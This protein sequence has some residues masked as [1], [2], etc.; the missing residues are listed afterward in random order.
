MGLY[1]SS[2]S[3]RGLAQDAQSNYGMAG[4]TRQGSIT[5][6]IA[7]ARQKVFA[8]CSPQW[9]FVILACFLLLSVNLGS[10]VV[11]PFLPVMAPK[12][13]ISRTGVA[14]VMATYSA[15]QIMASLIAGPAAT[16]FGRIPVL[17]VGSFV[18]GVS[19]FAFGIV[20]TIVPSPT[21][22]LVL[23]CISRGL[24]GVGAAFATTCLLAMLTDITPPAERGQVMGI[25]EFASASGWTVGPPIG[26]LLFAAG[27]WVLPFEILGILPVVGVM[28][29]ILVQKALGMTSSGAMQSADDMR[30]G[31][32]GAAMLPQPP[33]KSSVALLREVSS[34]ELYLIASTTGL[35]VFSWGLWDLGNTVWLTEEFGFSPEVV[36]LMFSLPPLIYA[37]TTFPAGKLSDTHDRRDLLGAGLIIEGWAMVIACGWLASYWPWSEAGLAATPRILRLIFNIV[38]CILIGVGGPLVIVPCLPEMVSVAQVNTCTKAAV[39]GAS[40]GSKKASKVKWSKLGADVKGDDVLAGAIDTGMDESGEGHSAANGVTSAE[41]EAVTNMI[42]SIFTFVMNLGGFLGPLFGSPVI[43]AVGFR[44]AAGIVGM[45]MIAHGAFV[46]GV[47]RAPGPSNEQKAASL[48]GAVSP[49][50]IEANTEATGAGDVEMPA[51]G[52]PRKGNKKG[53]PYAPIGGGGMTN[54]GSGDGEGTEF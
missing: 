19:N 48:V 34:F 39:H 13:G 12:F 17:T 50:H 22:R 46:L 45:A 14:W 21:A 37:I 53:N 6:F 33:V 29:L 9:I 32:V 27:G 38:G 43:S 25:A 1:S 7:K 41:N 16:R 24:Q 47:S 42:S 54:A 36:G 28:G 52:L 18:V 51:A 23:F 40:K 11:T 49:I 35:L 8:V 20:P 2:R 26:A 44:G 4:R 10:A 31:A 15:F 3:A 30:G 5:V